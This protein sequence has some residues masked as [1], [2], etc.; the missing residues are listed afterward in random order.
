MQ[1]V[2]PVRTIMLKLDR[3]VQTKWEKELA[4]HV[5]TYLEYNRIFLPTIEQC[6]KNPSE[7]LNGAMWRNTVRRQLGFAQLQVDF[8]SI[9]F[10]GRSKSFMVYNI[11]QR[12]NVEPWANIIKEVKECGSKDK[13][14]FRYTLQKIDG[15]DE[16]EYEDDGLVLALVDNIRR[17]DDNDVKALKTSLQEPSKFSFVMP[18]TMMESTLALFEEFASLVR[19]QSKATDFFGMDR[20]RM[21]G[22]HEG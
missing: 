20:E 10:H 18:Y 5:A 6:Q 21:L 2:D 17:G 14:I 11:P 9:I 15:D 3:S 22:Y 13:I 7:F 16:F 8:L 4:T 12:D 19:T 1:I